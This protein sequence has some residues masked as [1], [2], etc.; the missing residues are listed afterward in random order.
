MADQSVLFLSS[1]GKYLL[2]M[3]Q[4]VLSSCSH[5]IGHIS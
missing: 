5:E 3:M 4:S 2:Y 1:S